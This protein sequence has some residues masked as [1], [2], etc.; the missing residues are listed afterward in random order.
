M[1]SLLAATVLLVAVHVFIRRQVQLHIAAVQHFPACPR[2]WSGL[3]LQRQAFA[4][5]ALLPVYGSSELTQ[6]QDNRADIFSARIP[7]ASA[8]FSSAIRARRA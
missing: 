1:A 3:A 2:S 8:R 6:P 5:P 7:P 4:D